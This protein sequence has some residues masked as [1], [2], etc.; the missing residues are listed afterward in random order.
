MPPFVELRSPARRLRRVNLDGRRIFEIRIHGGRFD[1]IAVR[2]EVHR[3]DDACYHPRRFGAVLPG[4][5]G[6]HCS[7]MQLRTARLCLDCQEIHDAQQCPVC[8]SESFAFISRWIPAP[9]R[10]T[11]SRSTA[12]PPEAAVYRE[13]LS[14][15]G[16]DVP[17]AGRLLK[18]GAIGLATISLAG[19]LWRR[20]SR[21][22]PP[23][24]PA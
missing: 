12:P 4:K 5:I 9:E 6:L 19:W 1:L 23:T 21:Q 20:H 24:P 22:K 13:L 15:G 14:A 8:A 17:K 16:G 11:G 10:R 18:R 3:D 7:S 2:V